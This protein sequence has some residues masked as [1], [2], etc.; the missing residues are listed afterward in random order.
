[1]IRTCVPK[2]YF[3][4]IHVLKDTPVLSPMGTSHCFWMDAS[5]CIKVVKL[6][7]PSLHILT[8][9]YPTFQWEHLWDVVFIAEL[10]LED[11]FPQ[12]QSQGCRSTGY[13]LPQPHLNWVSY[14]RYIIKFYIWYVD[15]IM[16]L[17]LKIEI[18]VPTIL[19]RKDK[20]FPPSNW[21]FH[22][23]LRGW[24]NF[25]RLQKL[26]LLQFY[27]DVCIFFAQ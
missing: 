12:S 23:W 13:E 1:M 7:L 11:N 9:F 17:N 26:C 14:S 24:C 22:L 15:K 5:I 25:H 21:Q 27:M 6:K 2:C 16:T 4:E 20:W 8:Y 19:K 3:W 10:T 18:Q